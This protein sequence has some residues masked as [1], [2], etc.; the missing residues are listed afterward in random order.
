MSYD[1]LIIESEDS[2]RE[3]LKD[4]FELHGLCVLVA[5]SAVVA[6]ELLKNNRPKIILLDYHVP[7]I[8]D[9]HFLDIK[10]NDPEI[11]DIPLIV[12]TTLPNKIN[13]SD[14]FDLVQKPFNLDDF[15]DKI[16][17]YL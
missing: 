16:H 2:I 4:F 12:T 15:L 14:D 11:C 6:L 7:K 3:S 9:E 10:A 1:V 17:K 5:D 13:L 8:N